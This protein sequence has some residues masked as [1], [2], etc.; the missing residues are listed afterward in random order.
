[1]YEWAKVVLSKTPTLFY[2]EKGVGVKSFCPKS[3][4]LGGQGDLSQYHL[5]V[6]IQSYQDGQQ[7]AEG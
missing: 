7:Y 1:M 4:L 6:S 5:P 3:P 2:K